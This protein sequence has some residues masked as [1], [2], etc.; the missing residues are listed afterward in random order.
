M[1][2]ILSLL[3]AF[4]MSL[5]MLYA[6]EAERN[7]I[8]ITAIHVTGSS[9]TMEAKDGVVVYY[10]DA[11]IHADE[12]RYDKAAHRLVL[13]G[14]VE[15]IGY[16]GTKEHTS[17]MEI[18]THTNVVTFK[19][20]FFTNEND[21]WL[22]TNDANRTDGNYTFGQSMLS[23]CDVEDP[24]WKMMFSEAKYDSDDKYMQVYDA[25]VYFDDM[26]V[27]YSPYLAFSTDNRRS[28]GLLFPLFG[29]SSNEGFIYEQP[30]YWAISDSMDLEFNPQIRTERSIGMYA[31]YRFADS[32]YSSGQLRLGYFK[33]KA[34]YAEAYALPDERHYGLEFLYDS[35]N[36]FGRYLPEA[37]IDG[38]YVNIT[39]L[40]DIDYLNLQKTH[41]SHFGQV[42][43]QESRLNYFLHN[44]DWY[45]AMY[46]K[47][48]ID[49]RLPDNGSTIQT[50]PN[51]QFHKYLKS[52]FWDNL[53]YS[54]DLQTKRLDRKDG[55]TLNQ[56]EFR[57]PIELNFSLFDDYLNITLG[58]EFYYGRFFF[59][60]DD[61]LQYDYFQYNSNVHTAKLFSDLTREYDGFIHVLQPSLQYIKP[62]TESQKPVDF[63]TL[64]GTEGQV[65]DLFSVGLPEEEVLFSLN[66]YFYDE[67]MNLFFFQRL[68]QG[69][70]PNRDYELAEISNE[71]RYMWKHWT[72]YNRLYYSYEFSD[73]SESSTYITLNEGD[74]YVSVGHT[75]KQLLSESDNN[76]TSN[77]INVNFRYDYDER[78]SFNGGVTYNIEESTS[79]LW[80]LGAAYR[81]DCWSI[82]AQ[83]NADILPRPT[84]IPGQ[85][86]YTQEYS[87]IVQL[88]FIPFASIGTGQ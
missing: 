64:I 51:L 65:R 63:D 72:F 54:L 83:L 11:I 42:P 17:H 77:D 31:T 78:L 33:D 12:A 32:P 60:N 81:R 27:F 84:D 4:L 10:Q 68:S 41:L 76:V 71:M 66:Q 37:Y 87:F 19:K 22:L 3:A 30:V 79:R 21:V 74:Y 52:L 73:I 40:N 39:L 53:T 7:H 69:Y 24:L 5:G 55:P 88:N 49:T 62:G 35:S 9:T 58:E 16:H 20:L 82:T 28:S 2:S 50:L 61:T 70:Y 38:L 6:E 57:V 1:R 25:K 26:P 29:Y 56:A 59:G 36:L 46:A 8:E 86:T 34:S 85:N 15:M 18:D 23:S 44:D 48:Y 14:N 45:G 80:H 43:L 75:F 47:Y 13:D 67:E